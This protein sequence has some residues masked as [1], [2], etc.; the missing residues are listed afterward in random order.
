MEAKRANSCFLAIGNLYGGFNLCVSLYA[1]CAFGL[2]W[3]QN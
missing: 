2:I 3:K 1:L